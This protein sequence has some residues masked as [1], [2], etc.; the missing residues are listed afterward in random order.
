MNGRKL[1]DMDTDLLKEDMGSPF[2]TTEAE[3]PVLG[4]VLTSLI[5]GVFRAREGIRGRVGRVRAAV[6]GLWA[7]TVGGGDVGGSAGIVGR[8]GLNGRLKGRPLC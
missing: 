5:D 1:D 4:P 2:T 6:E 8:E 3:T 7:V